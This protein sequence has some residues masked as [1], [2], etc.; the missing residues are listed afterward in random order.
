MFRT[1]D[2]AQW[3]LDIRFLKQ[4]YS[5]SIQKIPRM[6]ESTAVMSSRH[7]EPMTCSQ[8]HCRSMCRNH[9]LSC[10]QFIQIL[11]ISRIWGF[12]ITSKW[13]RGQSLFYMLNTQEL[14]LLSMLSI[15]LHC[16]L[17]ERRTEKKNT[18]LESPTVFACFML[19]VLMH[20]FL[21]SASLLINL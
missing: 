12:C 4:V 21:G 15:R 19:G 8:F 14:K 17:L 10:Y 18:I 13:N 7:L 2:T 11:D 3:F 9:F 16:R 6:I 5:D 20:F 1:K